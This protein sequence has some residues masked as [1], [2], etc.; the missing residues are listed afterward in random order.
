MTI[1]L[2]KYQ[3]ELKL[4][5]KEIPAIFKAIK[6]LKPSKIDEL[7]NNTHH[8]VFAETDCLS[9]ANCCKTTSPVFKSKDIESIAKYLKIK[10]TSLTQKYLYMDDEGDYVLHKSPCAFLSDDNSCNIYDVRPLACQGYPHTNMRKISSRL[11]LTESNVHVCPA[12]FEIVKRIDVILKANK[13]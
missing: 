10:P 7:I 12:V 4:N 11:P 8:E 3:A 2:E 5:R 13:H 1:D 6:K 9:C